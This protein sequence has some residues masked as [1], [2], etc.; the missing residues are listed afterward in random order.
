[1]ETGALVTVREKFLE[2]SLSLGG[3]AQEEAL[4]STALV[5]VCRHRG[6]DQLVCWNF[7]VSPIS[8][9]PLFTSSGKDSFV[10]GR[11]SA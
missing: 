11:P 5:F 2:E 9:M 3:C 1:M 8:E 6:G 4:C 7:I 10:V